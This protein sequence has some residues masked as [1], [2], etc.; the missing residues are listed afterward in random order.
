MIR[1]WLVVIKTFTSK[2]CYTGQSNSWGFMVCQTPAEEG[3][4][5]VF[6][7]VFFPK[8]F[9][10]LPSLLFCSFSQQPCLEGW[11]MGWKEDWWSG[12]LQASLHFREIMGSA[13]FC[14]VFANL[15]PQRHPKPVTNSNVNILILNISSSLNPS[16]WK[17]LLI[18]LR[19]TTIT[20]CPPWTRQPCRASR[21]PNPSLTVQATCITVQFSTG[22]LYYRIERC[23]T[24][25][26]LLLWNWVSRLYRGWAQRGHLGCHTCTTEQGTEQCSVTCFG[27]SWMHQG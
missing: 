13:K 19:G 8:C 3:M 18:I 4:Q 20:S 26:C 17:I 2:K 12:T 23:S 27:V 10:Q 7:P 11:K 1:I 16:I 25:Q 21:V 15:S 22:H 5:G 14:Q 6:R 24:V 9:A